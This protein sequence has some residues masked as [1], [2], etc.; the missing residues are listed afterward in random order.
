MVLS[1]LEHFEGVEDFRVPCLVTYPL[2]ELLFSTLSG[3]LCGAEDWEDI[4]TLGQAHITWLRGYLPFHQGIASSDIWAANYRIR[5]SMRKALPMQANRPPLLP[6][7]NPSISRPHC[8]KIRASWSIS[9]WPVIWISPVCTPCMSPKHAARSM[10]VPL[11]GIS[12][13][14]MD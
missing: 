11:W 7:S 8:A 5:M 9:L 13:R 12:T 6:S 3:L 4:V 2:D 14:A 10:T 1:F